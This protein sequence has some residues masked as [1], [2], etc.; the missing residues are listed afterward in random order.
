MKKGALF[1]LVLAGLAGAAIGGLMT[2]H[3]DVQ[4]FGDA[5]LQG[6]LIGCEATEEV[7][8]DIV[9]TSEFS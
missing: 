6:G 1:L 4:M 5:A 9:N 2:W 8:C 7:N 3:H